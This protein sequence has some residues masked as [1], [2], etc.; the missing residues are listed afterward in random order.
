VECGLKFFQTG[1]DQFKEA[2]GHGLGFTEY[3][4]GKTTCEIMK[5]T[6]NLQDANWMAIIGE[7]SKYL[8]GF[9][10]TEGKSDRY[11]SDGG[12]G[13]VDPHACIEIDW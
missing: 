2:R 5:S 3:S 6:N 1:K 4:W 12:Y 8:S 7:S 10:V 13:G 9:A 11:L